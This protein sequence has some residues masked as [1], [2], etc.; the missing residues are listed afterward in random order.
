MLVKDYMTRHPLMAEPDMLIVDAKRYMGENDIR[1]LPVVGSGKRLVGL[2]TRQTLLVD[3]GKLGS[4]DVWEITRYLSHV[5]VADVM[6]PADQVITIPPDTAIEDAARVM[7]ERRVGSLPVVED[8]VVVG[9]ITETDML[10][11]L[12]K[13]MGTRLKG[14]R[15]TIRMTM[16][17]GELAKLVGAIAAQ[18]WGIDALG[19]VLA[20]KDPDKWEA[21]VKL[22]QPRDEVVAVLG[23]IE[24]QEIIDVRET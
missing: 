21:V 15:V 24:G 22:R 18:G 6:V 19:G 13:M 1:H 12:V 14:V 11:Q 16:L 5:T 20:P 10:N 3:P 7:V 9:M 4:L 8:D 2:V 17:R 23:Q